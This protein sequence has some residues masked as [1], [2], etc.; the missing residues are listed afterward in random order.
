[1]QDFEEG[2]KLVDNIWAKV[3]SLGKSYVLRSSISPKMEW[4]LECFSLE[5]EIKLWSKKQNIS[6]IEKQVPC[7]LVE[8]QKST[9]LICDRFAE[10]K[11]GT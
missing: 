1:M 5:N 6:E 2:I 4:K 11:L 3:T 8:L 10:K 7:F 9:G